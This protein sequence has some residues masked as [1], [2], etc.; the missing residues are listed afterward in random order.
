MLQAILS[1]TIPKNKFWTTDYANLDPAAEGTVIPLLYGTKTN[2]VPVCIDTTA[3]KYKI[4]GHAIKSV[5]AVRIEDDTLVLTTDYSVDVANGEITILTSPVLA[6]ST[7]YYMVVSST[8]TIDGSNYVLFDYMPSG[9]YSGGQHYAIDG[10]SVWTGASSDLCFKMWGRTAIGSEDIQ[11]LSFPTN[12]TGWSR[13]P[14]KDAAARTRIAQ[15]FQ[16]PSWCTSSVYLT[17][18]QLSG[19][20]VGSPTGNVYIK[21]LSAYN[22]SEVQVG[23][24]SYPMCN[25]DLSAWTTGDKLTDFPVRETL[26]V[27]VA[28]DAKGKT[29]TASGSPVMTNSMNILEDVLNNELDTPDTDLNTTE[30]ATVEAAKTEALALYINQETQT[31][32]FIEKLEAGQLI[33]IIPDKDGLIAPKYFTSDEPAGT[34]H[35]VDE[36]FVTFKMWHDYGAIRRTVRIKYDEGASSLATDWQVVESSSDVARYAYGVNEQ[37]EVETYLKSSTDAS[38]LAAKMASLLGSPPLYIE[39]ETNAGGWDRI[40][41]DK[42]KITRTRAA[43]AGGTLSAVLFRV[44]SVQRRAASKTV[45]IKAILDTQTY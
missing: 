37:M 33:K 23:A 42:V 38:T 34:P 10:S 11:L 31:Q 13:T 18:I 28:V 24:Q 40:P 43:Y 32:E 15:G 44:L 3:G 4:A 20:K 16:L 35:F 14:F 7:Q 22:P 2:I 12:W 39:F 26:N 36:D 41:T 8:L 5:D 19:L 25:L 6:P 30:F 17:R 29:T 9:G 27:Q 21:I 45:L 1:A